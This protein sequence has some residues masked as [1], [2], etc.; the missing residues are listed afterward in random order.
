MYPASDALPWRPDAGDVSFAP[1]VFG[2][3]L[4]L[5]IPC[6]P[7]NW[8]LGFWVDSSLDRVVSGLVARG[9]GRV[10]SPRLQTRVART[11]Q[12]LRKTKFS[13]F[14]HLVTRYHSHP[15]MEMKRQSCTN[16]GLMEDSKENTS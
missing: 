5:P 9:L 10:G 4:G 11:D 15:L 6:K 13:L 1:W 8:A 7:C 2:L 16:G 14:F 3:F 12:T